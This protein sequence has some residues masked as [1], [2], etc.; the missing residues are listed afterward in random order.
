MIPKNATIITLFRKEKFTFLLCSLILYTLAAPFFDGIIK[1]IFFSRLSFI[2]VL[3]SAVFAVSEKK[4]SMILL[5]LLSSISAVAF[6]LD[7]FNHTET[8]SMVNTVFKIL[9]T[10]CLIYM[11]TDFFYH[12]QDV[13]RDTISAALIGYLLIMLLWSDLYYLLELN[14]PD[15]FT[16][17]HEAIFS[18]AGVLRY[19]SFVTITTLGYGDISPVSLQA[20]NL[21]VFE[22][23]VGQMYLAVLIARLVGV[24]AAQEQGR[25]NK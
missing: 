7:L 20:R 2:L 9:F 10:G 12:C 6:V 5:L 3:L 15:S 13:S 25:K 22:A 23:F 21:A 14:Y 19:F 4:K 17:G 8:M 18:D 1:D 16:V 24:H 11:I